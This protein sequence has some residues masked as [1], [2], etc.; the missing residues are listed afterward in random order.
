[1]AQ[2]GTAIVA[3][4]F[5]LLL[6]G[7][8]A[9]RAIRIGVLAALTGA[10]IGFLPLGIHHGLSLVAHLSGLGL[11]ARGWL[12]LAFALAIVG[13]TLAI[14]TFLMVLTILGLEQHQAFAALAH[15]GYKHFVRLRVRQDG[16]AID[17]WVLGKIDPLNPFDK[18]LLVDQFTWNNPAVSSAPCKPWSRSSPPSATAGASPTNR[19]S[20]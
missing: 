7:W 3:A 5:C 19:S 10:F 4:L 11:T 20:G 9:G 16:S 2:T 6:G 14:G 15:P 8:R 1:M 12:A 18:V 13:G 17:G